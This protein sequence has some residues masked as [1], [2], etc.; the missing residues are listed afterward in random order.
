MALT[1]ANTMIHN[2]ATATYT[3]SG[4]DYG[5]ASNAVR[6]PVAPV[7]GVRLDP[8]GT[9]ADPGQTAYGDPGRTVYFPYVLT[10]TGNTIDSYDLNVV[11]LQG[12]FLPSFRAIYLDTN[13]NGRFDSGENEISRVELLAPGAFVNLLLRIDIPPDAPAGTHLAP[14]LYHDIQARSLGDLS[15]I[16]RDNV[17]RV[18]LVF[19]AV[20]KISKASAVTSAAPGSQVDFILD[21]INVGSLVAQ[22]ETVLVDGVSRR[23]VLVRDY[24]TSAVDGLIRYVPG[25]LAASPAGQRRLA[26]FAG[27]DTW[28]ELAGAT[29]AAL[30]ARIV[31]LGV[32]FDNAADIF[33]PSQQARV[34]FRLAIAED[35]P[36]GL[37]PNTS[38][39][40]YRSRQGEA[41]EDLATNTVR[42]TVQSRV[43]QVLI[44]PYDEP[45]AL[46]D[47]FGELN[48]NG[49]VTVDPGVP[50]IN[51]NPYGTQVTGNTVYFLNTVRN[52][53]NAPDTINVS[54][55]A[56]T[57]LPPS[58]LS[59]VR[60]MAVS[61]IVPRMEADG[62]TPFLHPNTGKPLFAPSNVST[63]FDSNGDGIPDTGPL[64]P[65]ESR[66]IAV[67]MIIPTDAL[68]A[69]GQPNGDNDGQGYRITLRAQSALDPSQSNLTSNS[70]LRVMAPGNFWDPFI[71]DHDAPD[72]IGIG[73]TIPYVNIFGNNGPG[74]VFNTI[75]RDELSDYLT[76]V[77][78]ISNGVI[79]DSTGSG[80]SITVTGRYEAQTH[81]VVWHIFE[82]PSGFTGR[83]G[84]SVDVA[85]GTKDGTE[86]PNIFSITSDQTQTVRLSNQVLAVVGGE[87]ILTIN[88][89]VSS[90]KVDLGDPLRYEVEVHNKGSETLT[91]AQLTDLLPRG[92]RYLS[93]SATLDGKKAEPVISADGSTL[94]WTLG[95]LAPNSSLTIAY[96]CVV[97]TDARLGRNTN[98]VTISAILPMGSRLQASSGVDVEVEAG[99]F[100]N[101]SII[102]GRVF[103]DH[104]D[105]RLQNHAEPGIQGVRLILEDG[106]YVLT[107]REGKYHFTGIKPGM[108]VLRLDQ[109]TLP[110][111]MTAAIVDSQNALNPLSR[112]VELR[113]G[114]PHKAN[115]RVLPVRKEST[116][117]APSSTSATGAV[118]AVD[119]PGNVL[120]PVR[121]STEGAATRVEIECESALLA[122]VAVDAASGIVHVMLPGVDSSKQPDRL[123][124][125]DPNVASL[126]CYMDDEDGRAKL[127]LRLRKRT[128]GYPAVRHEQTARGVIV[129]IGDQDR[130]PDF[131]PSPATRQAAPAPSPH[132]FEALILSPEPDETFI[133]SNQIT[134]KTAFFLAGKATLYVNGDVVPEERIGQRGVD[135]VARRMTCLYYGV[136]LH[137]GKNT[138]RLEVLNPGDNTPRVSEVSVLRAA[139]PVKI[140]LDVTPN[141][142][143]ADGLTEPQL[144]ITLL[145]DKGLPTGHGSVVT[146]TVDKGDILSPDLRLT[147]PGH[148]AQVRDGMAMIRLNSAA[149]P[150]TRS[151]RVIAGDL[152][153]T[154]KVTF[155]PHQRSWILSGIASTTV[156]D[157]H[158]R[159]SGREGGDSD[160][161]LDM[162]NRVAWFAKGSLPYNMV[163][164]TSYDS[165]KPRDD[166]KIFSEQDPLKYYPVYGDESEQ[167]YEAQSRD[168]LYVKVEKDQSY[169]MYGD[170]ETGLDKAQLAAYQR[171]MT[172]AKL[173][174]ESTYLD[175][176]A[177]FSRND[178]V[179]IK[180][181]EIRG[182]GVSGYY[183]LPDKNIIYN[184]ERIV[185]ET[186]DRWHPDVVL[187]SDSM[188]R[189]TD[190]SIDYDTGRILFKRPVLSQDNDNNPIFIVADYEVDSRKSKDYNSYGGRA[191]L[192]NAART[193]AVGVTQIRDESAPNDHV[194]EGV[195]ASIQLKPGLVLS[196]ELAQ[197]SSVDGSD[198]SAMRL[199]LE[200]KYDAARYRLYYRN[201]GNDF[202]NQSMSGDRAG[203]MTLG[204]DGEFDLNDR[205][206]TKEEFYTETDRSSDRRR[207][208]AIHDFI[209]KRDTRE[210]TLGLGY[211]EEEDIS[212]S[213]SNGECLRS[214]F[215]RAGAGFNLSQSLRME[216]FHQQAFGDSGTDQ[217]TRSNADVR[218][219][220]NRYADLVL[221]AERRE[222]PTAG[223]EYNATFGVEAKLNESTSAFNRLKLE[224]SASGRRVRSG[225][226]LDIS[227]QVSSEWR[228]GG[229]A[230][231]SHAVRKSKQASDDDF[232][233][234]TLSSEY[235]PLSGEGTAVSRYEMR[236]ED[237][238]T[239][240]LTE[241]G[242]TLKVGVD[243]TLF[244][245][246]IINYIAAKDDSSDSL[247]LDLLVGCA[248]R[249]VTW[250]ALNVIGDIEFKHEKDTDVADWGRLS[251][252]I[253]SVEGNWQPCDWLILEAKYACKSTSAEY[254]D[255]ALFSDVKAMAARVDITDRVFVA[256]G[257]RVL[258]QYDVSAHSLSYGA[259][260]GFN[261]VKDLR[262]AFGYNFE[263][264]ED[265]DFSRGERWDKGF[266]VALH[267]KFDES[268]FGV[269]RRLEGEDKP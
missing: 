153:Q 177:F 57:N 59:N 75:I 235:R 259:T 126:R 49:D 31:E 225:S 7:Y 111:G 125:D 182:R 231:L 81:D 262:L 178:Q 165:K 15:L 91:N 156:S 222:V 234:L 86:I 58:W 173:H 195:D 56:L 107:D 252:L 25:T 47:I 12:G 188:T 95:T 33:V 28:R 206:S 154:V 191:E 207:H 70:I 227:H 146:V 253:L 34:T 256:I 129:N 163:M 80:Q 106:T 118:S 130:A 221:G 39:V 113:Y 187:K 164:T 205:W 224:N 18:Q 65:G 134:I 208:V 193:M 94:R 26:R 117:E 147:E 98:N 82:I 38:R 84:F 267:W 45:A 138:L 162:D 23:G 67:R 41:R 151:I 174:A 269:L 9:V 139:T 11:F 6:N 237:T 175:V 74:P 120:R 1:P 249:P 123:A 44:G 201:I 93:G 181:L 87:N 16:D 119:A 149:T 238:E 63:L 167:Q 230:E 179:Q 204:F 242:G 73:T 90:D 268:I 104:N 209:Y 83:I 213:A 97:T 99:M 79:Y 69:S 115:F 148:Q 200:G 61:G 247:S 169:V 232:W 202:D 89:K 228:L 140:A 251:R 236:D 145:D 215:A 110:P 226:G 131:D 152:D 100:H 176:D 116:A 124:L 192:H 50:V 219:T 101:D 135:V 255:S 53:A 190:Y 180:G 17:N 19:D 199:E 137:P 172:G 248:Y 142:L 68:A 220:L 143:M 203:R 105:D 52:N 42:V 88:K 261:V 54:I 185:I 128:S 141:P 114:T 170:F 250:D 229:T 10:N 102:F 245:R 20:L 265:R 150:E 136:N 92:F 168:K 197:S 132:E 27:D 22:P 109:T 184:S 2:Q 266:F 161:K 212:R 217:A 183:T 71:K 211:T 133:S 60:I 32:L 158:R 243:Y 246:N 48:N 260:I 77:Q 96:A 76:N 257:G 241:I 14:E 8:D 78:N 85:A 4:R 5:V 244:G 51:P 186:R 21:V 108:H 13:G 62:V 198:G 189:F 46:G 36:A 144:R 218:Y 72:T 258:S 171:S 43:S 160:H 159:D 112:M 30:A 37:L 254:L 55:D 40:Q 239:S 210:L 216:L 127:Q 264:F 122:D 103:V 194:L 223:A 64:A 155:A 66:T 121:V 29:E 263:G 3:W 157:S 214:P 240:Y 35:H 166:G 233:A 196:G 24:L